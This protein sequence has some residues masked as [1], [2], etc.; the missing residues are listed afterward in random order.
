MV[1][2]QCEEGRSVAMASP[3]LTVTESAARAKVGVKVIYRA[4]Q[5]HKLKAVK[6][7]AALRIHV[8]WVD[9]WLDAAATVINPEAPGP[10]ILFQRRRH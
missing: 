6:V 7:G 3:W 2:N 10:E 1:R 8:E 9:A 4:V 5:T